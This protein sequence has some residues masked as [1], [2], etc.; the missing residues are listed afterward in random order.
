MPFDPCFYTH[1]HTSHIIHSIQLFSP[2]SLFFL[3]PENQVKNQS[4]FFLSMK[5]KFPSFHR[6]PRDIGNTGFP[7]F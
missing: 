6:N 4:P 7:S 5:I 2:V 1:T 3:A